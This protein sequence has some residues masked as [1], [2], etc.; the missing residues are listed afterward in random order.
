MWM[1]LSLWLARLMVG[2]S[3]LNNAISLGSQETQGYKTPIARHLRVPLAVQYSL[4]FV[5]CG[6]GAGVEELERPSLRSAGHGDGSA[7]H[8]AGSAGHSD[9]FAGYGDAYTMV[10]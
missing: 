2:G 9:G 7:G 1:F 8:G 10:L 3:P 6:S 4:F 5:Y